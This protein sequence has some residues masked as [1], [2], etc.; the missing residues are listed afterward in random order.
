MCYYMKS[1]TQCSDVPADSTESSSLAIAVWLFPVPVK[2][3][4]IVV[5]KFWAI[6]CYWIQLQRFCKYPQFQLQSICQN[7]LT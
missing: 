4:Q 1:V 3:I 6:V 7:D 5:L 2:M